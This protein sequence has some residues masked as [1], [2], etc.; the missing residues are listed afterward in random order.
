MIPL[1]LG[2]K[3]SLILTAIFYP[4]FFY[5]CL[6]WSRMAHPER[7]ISLMAAFMTS[8]LY[9]FW[10]FLGSFFIFF[11]ISFFLKYLPTLINIFK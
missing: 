9:S 7:N 11:L 6:G 3:I 8:F 10:F 2:I 4:I 5:L 1:E